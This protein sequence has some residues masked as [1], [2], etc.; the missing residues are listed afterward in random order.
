MKAVI[1]DLDGTLADSAPDIAA[2]LNGALVEGGL[3]PFGLAQAT[4][5]VGAGARKLVERALA[6]SGQVGDD[7]L[8]EVTHQRFL[9][10]YDAR[11]CV[12]TRL[13]PGVRASLEALSAGGWQLGICTNK[14]EALARLVVEQLDLS[15][16]IET[17]IGGRD[18]FA[19]KPSPDMVLLALSELRIGADHAVFVGDSAADVGAARAASLPVIAV[20]HGYSDRPAAQLG[21]D[22]VV[23]H[24]DQMHAA[25][26]A[27]LKAPAPQAAW[28]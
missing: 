25:C 8:V 10:C 1:F 27:L 21:A 11:P 5:M 7:A 23:D 4:A 14:P 3:A 9:A 24:F 2:A 26:E 13:Y 6:A 28:R 12:E 17:L 19:L 15:H 16:L 18:G 22:A 20:T